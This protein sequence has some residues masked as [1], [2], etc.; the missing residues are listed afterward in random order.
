MCL[1]FQDVLDALQMS[2]RTSWNDDIRCAVRACRSAQGGWNKEKVVVHVSIWRRRSFRRAVGTLSLTAALFGATVSSGNV[3]QAVQEAVAAPVAELARAA[4]L[5]D[6]SIEGVDAELAKKL[7]PLLETLFN[8]GAP[9]DQRKA[10]AVEVKT[11]AAAVSGSEAKDG[12]ARRLL[13]RAS[14]IEATVVAGSVENLQASATTLAALKESAGTVSTKLAAMKNGELWTP[15]L[16]LEALKGETVAADVLEQLI[17]NLTVTEAM[18]ADQSRFIGRKEFQELKAAAESHLA[19]T[20]TAGDDAAVRGELTKQVNTLLTSLLAWEKD[21]EAS[22]AESARA[23]WRTIRARF[24]AAADVLR[25]VI[26]EHYFN[27]NVHFTVSETLLSRLIADYRTESGTIADC[28][29][30][31]WVTGSQTTDISVAADVRPSA[32]TAAFDLKV[33]GNTRSNTRAQ[34]DP[35]TVWTSGN[36]YFWITKSVNFDGHH[37][38]SGSSSV[39][40]DTNS[41][42]VG[43]ATKY[44]GIP[45]IRGIVR[46]IASQQ[47]AESKPEA[48]AITRERLG[49]EAVSKFDSETGKQFGDLNDGLNKTLTSLEQRN[50]APDSIS[51]RSS[52]THI[53]VS[54]RTIGVSRLGGS[55]Q[56]PSALVAEGAAVQM[57]ESGL[58]NAIDALGFQGRSVNEKD[59]LKE[60]EA[61]LTDLFQRDIKLSDGEPEP[62]PA[63]EEPEPPTVFVFSKTDPIRVRFDNG[64]IVLTLRTGIQQEGREEIPEQIITVPIS[65]SLADGK[66]ILEPG[67]IKVASKAETDRAKQ[68]PRA[69]QIRRIMSRRIVRK[70][71]NAT[72]DLQA[73]GDKKL[74]VTIT[75]IQLNDGW[76][77]AEM[78]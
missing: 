36:H 7:S 50:V 75:K 46:N 72:I 39:S 61:A 65:M 63:G 55:L 41:H 3:L 30:G 16:H 4:D 2:D 31:A 48:D 60:L 14:L 19:A 57:H 66:L 35:A 67:S 38:T 11:I 64:Q 32:N 76:V 56:P 9:A 5:S 69:N 62:A 70:E 29:M 78:Q 15:Y 74:P 58:N 10:A 42:T 59:F 45:I 77:T 44:D 24:P 49:S 54:A 25:P 53:A 33:N 13:R 8:A 21:A 23:A 47:I 26:N 27:H 1:I 40:V 43:L 22:H 52:N 51:A 17:K 34:K 6:E 37:V 68:L 73:A 12:L 28:I 18:N 20:G 71:M